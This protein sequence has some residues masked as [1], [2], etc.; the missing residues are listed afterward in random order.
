MGRHGPFTAEELA[1][2]FSL[3]VAT[4]ND[5]A[6]MGLLRP[7][8]THGGTFFAAPDYTR[9]QLIVKGRRLGFSLEE[10][11]LLMESAAHR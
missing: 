6:H 9:L 4:I 5:Y 11:K 7:T 10:I 3:S 8:T 1:T 2:T